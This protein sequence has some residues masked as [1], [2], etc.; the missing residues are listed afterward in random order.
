MV[1]TVQTGEPSRMTV[2]IS[3]PAPKV[4]RRGRLIDTATPLPL[5]GDSNPDRWLAG[6]LLADGTAETRLGTSG[7][8]DTDLV[9]CS[10]DGWLFEDPA[11]IPAGDPWLPFRIW[12]GLKGSTLES[13][14]ESM[15]DSIDRGFEVTRAY[16]FG[17]QMGRILAANAGAPY[18]RAFGSDPVNVETAVAILE[19]ALAANTYGRRG[20]IHMSS[21]AFSEYADDLILEDGVWRTALGTLV[22][23]DPAYSPLPDPENGAATASSELTTYLYATGEVF[24]AGTNPSWLDGNNIQSTNISRNTITRLKEAYGILALDKSIVS[25]VLATLDTNVVQPA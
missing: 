1:Q 6:V 18:G 2:L 22:V 15:S 23:A 5:P 14:L 4:V 16:A 20:T 12:E 7:E 25:A 9:A 11:C 24:W 19:D 17:L 13:T 21:G 8:A 3:N 10:D